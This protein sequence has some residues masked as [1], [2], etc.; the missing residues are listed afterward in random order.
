MIYS[1]N[2]VDVRTGED[3]GLVVGA[4]L[5]GGFVDAGCCREDTVSANQ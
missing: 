4:A 3:R 1:L 5:L 2:I